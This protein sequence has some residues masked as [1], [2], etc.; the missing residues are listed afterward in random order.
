MRALS[1]VPRTTMRSVVQNHVPSPPLT[2]R[3]FG[4][5]PEG[6]AILGRMPPILAL[7]T[8]LLVGCSS[9]TQE[10]GD[11]ASAARDSAAPVQDAGAEDAAEAPF[12]ARRLLVVALDFGLDD[13]GGLTEVSWQAGQE[14]TPPA[15]SL[16]LLDDRWFRVGDGRWRC[17]LTAAVQDLGP[18]QPARAESWLAR[19][20]Q[21]DL[22]SSDCD[23]ADDAVTAD[24]LDPIDGLEATLELGPT[25]DRGLLLPMLYQ[26]ATPAWTELEG[27]IVGLWLTVGDGTTELAYA[28]AYAADQDRVVLRQPDPVLMTVGGSPPA[29]VYRGT[30]YAAEPIAD[31]L[32]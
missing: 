6:G 8:P 2:R 29:G 10:T 12:Q 3:A 30:G 4:L 20:V 22:A 21:L 1:G 25:G 32:P 14:A 13:G 19:R 26:D 15:L 5:M 31:V 9:A 7:L 17:D 28:L 23:A 11:S 16:A 24:L 18:T 27:A